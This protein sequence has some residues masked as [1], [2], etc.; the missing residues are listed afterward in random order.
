LSVLKQLNLEQIEVEI[1]LVEAPEGLDGFE[2]E[3]DEM[4]SYV[5]K[6]DNPRWLWQDKRPS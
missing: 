2:S 3:L 1:R 4:W 6:K 5:E